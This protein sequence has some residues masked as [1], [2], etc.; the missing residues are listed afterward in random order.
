MTFELESHR[1]DELILYVNKILM[2][3]DDAML[4]YL[5]NYRYSEKLKNFINWLAMLTFFFWVNSRA[6]VEPI[7]AHLNEIISYSTL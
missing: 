4:Y 5:I 7:Q 3:M 1:E 6:Y 2:H